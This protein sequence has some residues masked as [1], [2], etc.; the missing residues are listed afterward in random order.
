MQ[1]PGYFEFRLNN[2]VPHLL[3]QCL[4]ARSVAAYTLNSGLPKT[5]SVLYAM[6]A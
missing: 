5:S 4:V 3:Q 1:A 6:I 2:G